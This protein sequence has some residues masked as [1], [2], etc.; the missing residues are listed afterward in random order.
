MENKERKTEDDF[1]VSDFGKL[2]NGGAII[3]NKKW[4]SLEEM[5]KSSVWTQILK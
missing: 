1:Q 3:K 2:M 4:E 5:T